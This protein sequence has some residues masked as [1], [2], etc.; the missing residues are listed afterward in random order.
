MILRHESYDNLCQYNKYSYLML[1]LHYM[2]CLQL[3]ENDNVLA[4]HSF[5]KFILD[6]PYEGILSCYH[7]CACGALF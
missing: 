2:N 4:V 6:V 5:W 7:L 1:L 3:H